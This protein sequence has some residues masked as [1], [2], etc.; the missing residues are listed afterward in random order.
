MYCFICFGVGNVDD[1]GFF[2]VFMVV[3]YF[4]YFVGIDVVIV[5]KNYIFFF[6]DNI[7]IIVFIVFC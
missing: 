1:Y 6:V 7:K 5:D 3:E 4:F 2:N